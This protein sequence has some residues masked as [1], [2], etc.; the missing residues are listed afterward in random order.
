MNNSIDILNTK[1]NLVKAS[2]KSSDIFGFSDFVTAL[3]LLIIVYTITNNRYKFRLSIVPFSLQYVSFIILI[4]IGIGILLTEFWFNK[5]LLIPATINDFILIQF[6]FAILLLIL[7]STWIYFAFIKPP[8]YCRTNYKK[9]MEETHRLIINGSYEDLIMLSDEIGRSASSIINASSERIIK[10]IKVGNPNKKVN[11]ISYFKPNTEFSNTAYNLL[12]LFGNR[13]F[14][15]EI[16]N[17]SPIT[18]MRFINNIE[19]TKK[20]NVPIGQ[21]LV[22]ISTE[23]LLNKNSIMYSETEKYPYDLIGNDKYF[24][25][26]LYGNTNLLQALDHLN[27]YNINFDFSYK[28]DE[29]QYQAFINAVL[30]TIKSYLKTNGV[31]WNH[32]QALNQAIDIIKRST[33]DFYKIKNIKDFDSITSSLSYKKL[34]ITVRFINDFIDLLDKYPS[35]RYKLAKKPKDEHYIIHDDLYDIVVD[36]ITEIIHNIVSLKVSKRDIWWVHHNIF[37]SEIQKSTRDK[38]IAFKI[39]N[40]KLRRRLFDEIMT[41]NKYYNFKSA[42]TLGYMLNILGLTQKDNLVYKKWKGFHWLIL[43]WTENNYLKLYK[44]HKDIAKNIPIGFIYFDKKKK[45]LLSKAN[46]TA[47]LKLKN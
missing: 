25:K 45:K 22:N 20:Y 2:Y 3:A 40:L 38:S 35:K 23:A 44:E 31:Y 12:L 14:C 10:Y 4:F 5:G 28:L 33:Y 16:I 21:F 34:E 15:R 26:T 37:W 30:V 36:I 43:K 41:F 27:P 24:I 6:L 18:V 9:F 8:I 47:F 39:I 1:I 11:P 13:K 29:E 7:V 46:S 19:K 32:Y 17:Y 42:R